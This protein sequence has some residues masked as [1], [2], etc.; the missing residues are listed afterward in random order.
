MGNIVKFCTTNYC[1]GSVTIKEKAQ[2]NPHLLVI[3]EDCL[4]NCGQCYMEPFVKVNEKFT[5]VSCYEDLLE[6]LTKG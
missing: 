1:N 3:E 4:G 6:S 2:K 5:A